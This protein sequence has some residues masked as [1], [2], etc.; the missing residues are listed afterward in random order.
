LAVLL[1]VAVVVETTHHKVV[2][3]EQVAQVAAVRVLIQPLLLEL[4]A[5]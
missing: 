2:L 3:Q 5:Q 1:L 4:L